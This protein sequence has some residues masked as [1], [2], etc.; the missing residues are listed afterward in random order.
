MEFRDY[1]GTASGFQ[2]SQNREIE[3]LFGIDDNQRINLYGQHYSKSLN[4]DD[5]GLKRVGK[6][7]KEENL[8]NVI[9]GWLR[10]LYEKVPSEF[11]DV[12]KKA[13]EEDTL[14]NGKLWSK[15]TEKVE[16]TLKTKLE[17]FENFLKGDQEVIKVRVAALFITSYL[18]EYSE[19]EKLLDALLTF[20]MTF[21]LWKS[22][23]SRM[24]ERM[25]GRRSGTGGSSGVDYLDNTSKYR[26]F[27]DLWSVRNQNIKSSILQ[28]MKLH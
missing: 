10:N 3:I 11:I 2:S 25:I 24:V 27:E 20:E 8:K 21:S 14:F 19:F 22:H 16:N 4:S 12:F 6:R 23:H 9:Y 5:E 1:V 18:N 13:I 15:D 17:N 26:V 28:P 7:L